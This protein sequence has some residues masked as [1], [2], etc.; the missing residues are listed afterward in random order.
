GPLGL[1]VLYCAELSRCHIAL[2]E[3][4]VALEARRRGA[5]LA[6]R[7]PEESQ[8]ATIQLVAAEDDWRSAMDD[9]WDSPLE[10]GGPGM[11]RGRV[12]ASYRAGVHASIART[13]ARMGRNERA[14]RRLASVVPA[15]ECAPAWAQGYAG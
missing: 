12:L 14:L 8:L 9:G 5:A 2:G 6:E 10:S 4:T 1:A 13:H 7:L 11:G 15:M 3:F